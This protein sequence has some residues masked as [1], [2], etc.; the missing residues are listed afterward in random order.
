M[1]WVFLCLFERPAKKGGPSRDVMG[2]MSVGLLWT[3]SSAG[4]SVGHN[5]L[6]RQMPPGFPKCRTLSL[7]SLPTLPHPP[8]FL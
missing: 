3:A 4:A 8:H 6:P 1:P 7:R 5:P 2:T